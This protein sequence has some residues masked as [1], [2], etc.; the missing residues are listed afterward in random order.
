MNKMPTE[1]MTGPEA[2]VAETPKIKRKRRKI[3][4]KSLLRPLLL[5]SAGAAGDRRR[6]LLA[7][8]RRRGFDR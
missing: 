3:A 8:Q 6:L 5:L 7:D 4:P 2:E 1:T